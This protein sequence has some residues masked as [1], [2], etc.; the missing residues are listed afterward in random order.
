[1]EDRINGTESCDFSKFE[2]LTII[3][4]QNKETVTFPNYILKIA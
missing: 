3:S 2:H 4:C 1:M